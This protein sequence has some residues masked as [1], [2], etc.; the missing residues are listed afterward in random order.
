[1]SSARQNARTIPLPE[2]FWKLSL[3]ERRATFLKEA[4]VRHTPI[5]IIPRDLLCGARFNT[6]SSHC[7]TKLQAADRNRKVYGKFG[8]REKVL[9]YYYYGFGNVGSTCG[10]LIPNYQRI[11]DEGFESV[12]KELDERY[13]A[14]SQWDRES[15][16]GAQIR[17]MMIATEMPKELAEKYREKCLMLVSAELG[18]VRKAEL[19]TMAANLGVVPWHKAETFWQA[20]QSLWITHMLVMSDENYPGP[21]VSF[22]RLDQYLYPYYLKSKEEGMSEATM[23]DILGCFWF[24][25]NTAYDAQIRVGNN[26]IT[27]GFGQLFNLSGRDAEGNDQTNDLTYLLL[28]VIDEITP[29][30][31]PKPNVRLHKN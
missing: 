22:G 9:D 29:M 11:L 24:H 30:L 10:H 21:G 27:A 13:A 18:P 5:E 16:S 2:N 12:R 7:L 14:M 8:A 6:L 25:C 4:I 17:A 3:K 23:K 28:D 15:S 26:G 31:E 1:M 19:E 20:I